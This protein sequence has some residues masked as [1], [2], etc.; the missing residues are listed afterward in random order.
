MAKSNVQE[1]PV[2]EDIFATCKVFVVVRDQS[3]G[4][5]L[6]IIGRPPE[7]HPAKISPGSPPQIGTRDIG[8]QPCIFRNA[9]TS[10]FGQYLVPRRI[11]FLFAPTLA[12]LE[13]PMIPRA[14]LTANQA[15]E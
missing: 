2:V 6:R 10:R 7:A 12:G 3:A 8:K 11:K 4:D 15:I 5:C 14:T 1:R 9:R 13:I